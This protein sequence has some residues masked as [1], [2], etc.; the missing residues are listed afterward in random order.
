MRLST[1]GPKPQPVRR[2]KWK[3]SHSCDFSGAG[4]RKQ[5]ELSD[6]PGSMDRILP[7]RQNKANQPYGVELAWIQ[8]ARNFAMPSRQAKLPEPA[9]LQNGTSQPQIS[10]IIGIN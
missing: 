10:C 1:R 7:Q 9:V 8:L 4:W 5:E 2:G 6:A 3:I